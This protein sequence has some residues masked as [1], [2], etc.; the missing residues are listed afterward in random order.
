M[1]RV[2]DEILLMS[3]SSIFSSG[4]LC[5]VVGLAGRSS[6]LTSKFVSTRNFLIDRGHSYCGKAI[7]DGPFHQSSWS[8][9][10]DGWSPLDA[11][12]AGLSSE[13]TWLQQLRGYSLSISAV[14]LQTYVIQFRR[15]ADSQWST[16]SESVHQIVL[17]T[18]IV[19]DA[20]TIVSSRVRSRSAFNSRRGIETDLIG[21][22][23]VLAATRLTRIFP[24]EA[25]R[26]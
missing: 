21:A 22:I 13:W 18:G 20:I 2:Q 17:L 6:A 23:R 7:Q 15:G 11:Q 24:S 26:L 14:L 1:S 9:S 16:I 19:N 10:L 12:S 25:T 3:N 4:K 8:R 5:R